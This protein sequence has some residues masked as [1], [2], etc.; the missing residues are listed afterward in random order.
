MFRFI[1][2]CIYQIKWELTCES[3][4]GKH[5]IRSQKFRYFLDTWV[6]YYSIF[7]RW[8]FRMFMGYHFY[9][10]NNSNTKKIFGT[11]FTENRNHTSRELNWKLTLNQINTLLVFVGNKSSNSSNFK[12]FMYVCKRNKS[13]MFFTYALDFLFTFGFITAPKHFR[14]IYSFKLNICF[15]TMM[16]VEHVS[17]VARMIF[18]DNFFLLINVSNHLLCV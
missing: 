12:T 17:C 14:K 1:L 8:I 11:R 7:F 10:S 13:I 4:T 3:I 18:L 9:C 16:V 15:I 2:R 5:V 6:G